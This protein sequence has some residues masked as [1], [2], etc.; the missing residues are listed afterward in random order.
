ME[1]LVVVVAAPVGEEV[2][3]EEEKGEEEIDEPLS[4]CPSQELKLEPTLSEN[5]WL[6]VYER[7]RG[8]VSE[9]L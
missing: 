8:R 5:L 9:R 6:Q 1:P 4:G 3:E 2:I 7:E